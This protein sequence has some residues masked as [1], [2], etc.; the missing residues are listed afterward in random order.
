MSTGMTISSPWVGVMVRTC[1]PSATAIVRD[2]PNPMDREPMLDHLLSP[3]VDSPEEGP[4][5][6]PLPGGSDDENWGAGE[7]MIG[8]MPC[9]WAAV[10]LGTGGSWVIGDP[11]L[12]MGCE[13]DRVMAGSA[14]I[15]AWDPG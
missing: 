13:S 14:P 4:R 6:S 7:K 8:R 2:P 10:L 15:A 1:W 12:R 5:G 3:P 11:W 9:S